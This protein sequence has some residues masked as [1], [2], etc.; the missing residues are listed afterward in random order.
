VKTRAEGGWWARKINGPR[1]SRPFA[2]DAAE[3]RG[4][5]PRPYYDRVQALRVKYQIGDGA[6]YFGAED[7]A[8]V[9]RNDGGPP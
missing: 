2:A 3:A 7:V 8:R 1:S 9:R 6:E 5:D 4:E